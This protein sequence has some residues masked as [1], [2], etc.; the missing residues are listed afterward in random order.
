MT[1]TVTDMELLC[2]PHRACPLVPQ[3]T[4]THRYDILAINSA[5]VQMYLQT[6]RVSSVLAAVGPCV[7]EPLT[8]FNSPSLLSR[9]ESPAYVTM[10]P[11]LCC[12]FI[13]LG[14]R[15]SK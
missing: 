13:F 1:T 11:D 4:N 9:P 7:V 15:S 8:C 14:Q 12:G 5:L 2:F 10:Q 6:G 3:S